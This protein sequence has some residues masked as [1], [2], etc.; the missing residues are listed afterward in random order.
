VP[1][2]PYIRVSVELR[3]V[4]R[5]LSPTEFAVLMS[6]GLR[7]NERGECCPSIETLAADVRLAGRSVFRA[8]QSL[9]ARGLLTIISGGGRHQ[10]NLYRL[11]RLFTYGTYQTMTPVSP[12]QIPLM[13]PNPDTSVTVRTNP[14]TGVI[15]SDS[16]DT[17]D[18]P[19]NHAIRTKNPDTSGTGNHDTSVTPSKTI[20]R[21]LRTTSLTTSKIKG[22][23]KQSGE[24]DPLAPATDASH[25]LFQVTNRKR[26]PNPVQKGLF[27]ACETEVGAERLKQAVDWAL[28]SG[29]HNVKSMMTAARK[30]HARRTTTKAGGVDEPGQHAAERVVGD[31]E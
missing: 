19:T 22:G 27:E 13:P 11:P 23:S 6:L 12:L 8:T 3:E 28:G 29:I 15:V 25:Y 26:W 9:K 30:G 14:D 20:R 2:H 21:M 4:Q 10:T 16:P 7:I 1:S 17:N 5:T 31:T 24:P 18:G